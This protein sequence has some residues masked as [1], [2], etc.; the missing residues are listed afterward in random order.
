MLQRP[1]P[2]TG[3]QASRR[4][5]GGYFQPATRGD[6]TKATASRQAL[7][8]IAPES[9]RPTEMLSGV[10]VHGRDLL[11]ADDAALHEYL[12]SRAYADDMLM[13]AETHSLDM[14][15][16]VRYLG[17]RVERADVRA[18]L[19]RL[20]STTVSYG[21]AGTRRYEDVQLLESW[22][23]VSPGSDV[24]R[25][26][27]PEPLRALMREQPAYAYVELAALPAMRSKYSSRLY[28]LLVVRAKAQP[29]VPGE[30]NVIV[31][32]ATPDEVAAW[33]GFPV[34]PDGKVHVGKLTDRFLAK[35][36]ADFADVRAFRLELDLTDRGGR[37]NALRNVTFRLRLSPPA[38]HTVPMFFKPSEDGARI[39][40]KDAAMYRV[41]SRTWRR[42]GKKYSRV[43][44]LMPRGMFELWQVALNEALTEEAMSDG[45]HTR[46]F[47]GRR[48]LDAVASRQ[49]DYAA[50]GFISEEADAP[51]L[52]TKYMQPGTG[53]AVTDAA[54]RERRLR[55][56]MIKPKAAEAAT[57]A[58]P[59][60]VALSLD[61]C[62]R[63]VLPASDALSLEDLDALVGTPIQRMQFTGERTVTL[64]LSYR[65]EGGSRDE[66]VLGDYAVSEADLEAILSRHGQHLEG[67]EEYQ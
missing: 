10:T 46:Q 1:K 17:S 16:A 44:G 27:L 50:W 29:W 67:M 23:E 34:G 58:E 26:R 48:L 61:D 37:G 21:D 66:W 25:Y 42:A 36:V 13:T 18:C 65:D 24:I 28:K 30:E 59:E 19:A 53:I 47:R 60:A 3:Y 12:V 45:F 35:V 38:H 20:R 22:I 43:M 15:D 32:T 56:G 41:Q 54:E 9:P 14:S 57:A 8:V 31:V 40:G 64:A 2:P 4:T 63:I 6:L 62:S 49:A 33:V 5:P 52:L 55:A 51:D 39:G 11:T 7:Q